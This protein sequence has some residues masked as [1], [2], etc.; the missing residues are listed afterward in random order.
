MSKK[1]LIVYGSRWGSTEEISNKF[2]Q[3]LEE[4]KYKVDILNLKSKQKQILNFN[5]YSG[6]LI[7]TGISIGKWTKH[8]KKFVTKNMNIINNNQ[9]FIVGIFLSSGLASEKEKRNE[10]IEKFI[11]NKFEKMGINLGDNIMYDAFGGVYD[12]SETTKLSGLMQKMLKMAGKEDPEHI[13]VGERK[14]FRDWDQINNFLE[15]FVS[16]IQ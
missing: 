7:G 15:K 10:A 6:I 11:L 13:V 5:D 16:K 1:I 8:V 12:L 3:Q 4:K 9:N 2:K 14:D